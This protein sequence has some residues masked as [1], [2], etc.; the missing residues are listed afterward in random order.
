M[1]NLEQLKQEAFK[2]PAVKD[3]YIALESEFSFIEKM[4]EMRS[5]AGLSQA[6]IAEK[7][8]TSKGNISR[9]ENGSNTTIKTFLNYAAACGFKVSLKTQA[10]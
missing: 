10:L 8:G 2:N 5:Q 7:L 9:L 4:L 1:D 3:E 6:E